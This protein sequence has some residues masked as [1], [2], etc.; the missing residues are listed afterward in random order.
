[1]QF[2]DQICNLDVALPIHET[3]IFR[4]PVSET[5]PVDPESLIHKTMK[6]ALT[7]LISLCLLGSCVNV[8]NE[9]VEQP[10]YQDG[11]FIHITKAYE[12]AHRVLMPLKMASM[13]AE[14]KDVLVYLDIEAVNFLMNDS[15]DI[16]HEGFESAHTYINRLVEQ[17]VGVY[18]CP[19]CLQVAGLDPANLMDGVQTAQKDKFFNFTKGRILSLSY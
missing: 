5:V 8:K 2:P 4:H 16:A 1:M 11:V 15:E 13:M 17:G 9:A 3:V 18:A 14:D 12:D 6:N 7:F 10:T 19:T